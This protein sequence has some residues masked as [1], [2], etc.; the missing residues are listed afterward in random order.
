MVKPLGRVWAYQEG[1]LCLIKKN[2]LENWGYDL[3]I[4][5]AWGLK[6]RAGCLKF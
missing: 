4:R 3:I 1:V 6:Q 5:M 2:W